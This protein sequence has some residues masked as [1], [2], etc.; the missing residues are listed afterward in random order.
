[1]SPLEAEMPK[2]WERLADRHAAYGVGRRMKK[3]IEPKYQ[4]D[5]TVRV[6]L[7]KS[8]FTRGYDISHTHQ[9]YV[10]KKIVRHRQLPAYILADENG[11]EVV[12]RFR[13]HQL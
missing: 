12:G 9:R 5:Q 2:N 1:M 6:S 3:S 11:V 13:E 7:E 4:V 8:I 10:I